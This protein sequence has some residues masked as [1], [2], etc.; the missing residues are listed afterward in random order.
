MDA[1]DIG[2]VRGRLLA[3]VSTLGVVVRVRIPDSRVSSRVVGSAG[4]VWI[5][6]TAG[7]VVV[8]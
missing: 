8:M 6:E 3:S 7:F 5:E 4:L 1:E 2:L